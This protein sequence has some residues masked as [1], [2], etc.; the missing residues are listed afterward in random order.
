MRSHTYQGARSLASLLPDGKIHLGEYATKRF[1][2][3]GT[4]ELGLYPFH[5]TMQGNTL[6]WIRAEPIP[7]EGGA[8]YTSGIRNDTIT[9]HQD[10][11]DFAELGAEEKLIL[12]DTEDG[13]G[14]D[15]FGENGFHDFFGYFE[16]NFPLEASVV[17]PT[18]KKPP[19]FLLKFGLGR[20]V[21]SFLRR[22]GIY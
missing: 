5:E 10:L 2:E 17:N 22:S 19:R 8:D 18:Y 7:G 13:I 20:R 15:L 4:E 12:I 6:R 9:I 16:H 1:R 14:F 3:S 11:I 21:Y